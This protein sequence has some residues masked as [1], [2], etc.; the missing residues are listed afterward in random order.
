MF[1]FW[2]GRQVKIVAG[3]A[4]RKLATILGR[5]DDQQNQLLMAK[6]TGNFKRG[7]ERQGVD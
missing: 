2:H 1:I 6:A 5:R 3:A 4:G 7:N